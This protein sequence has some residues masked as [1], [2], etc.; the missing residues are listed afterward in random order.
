MSINFNNFNGFKVEDLRKYNPLYYYKAFKEEDIEDLDELIKFCQG[1]IIK[2]QS[3]GDSFETRKSMEESDV[4]IRAKDGTL[5]NNYSIFDIDTVIRNYKDANR[6]YGKLKEKYNIDPYLS[7]KTEDFRIIKCLNNNLDKKK[8][9]MFLDS[10]N[11]SVDYFLKVTHTKAFNN[12]VYYREMYYMYLINATIHRYINKTMY[13]YFDVDKYSKK[14]LKNA[15][16]SNGL[17]YFDSFPLEYQRRTYKR[18]NDLIR[19][20]GTNDIFPII[21]DIFSLEAIDINKYFLAKEENDL[22]FYKTEISKLFNQFEDPSYEYEEIVNKDPYWRN[23]KEEV[24]NKKFNLLQ[25]KYISTDAIIDIISN[26]KGLSYL[27]SIINLMKEDK[28]I[29][30]DDSFSLMNSRISKSRIDVFDAIITLNT[31]LINYIKWNDRIKNNKNM[32]IYGYNFESNIKPIVDD[33]RS[34][35][36][37]RQFDKSDYTVYAKMLNY[38]NIKKFK[39]RNTL[40]YQDVINEYESS[41]LAKR[42]FKFISEILTGVNGSTQLEYYIENDLIIDGMRYLWT[43]VTKKERKFSF[44][45]ISYY[46]HFMDVYTKFINVMIRDGRINEN[47]VYSIMIEDE[48]IQKELDKFVYNMNMKVLNDKYKEYMDNK[49][50]DNINSLVSTIR[51][52][53]EVSIKNNKYDYTKQI[54][55][56]PS[57]NSYISDILTYEDLNEDYINVSEIMSMYKHNEDFRKQLEDLIINSK[58]PHLTKKFTKLYEQ[59]FITKSSNDIFNGYS[60]YSDYLMSKNPDLYYYTIVESNIYDEDVF[61]REGIFRERIFELVASIDNHLNLKEQL[62]TNSNFS[63]VVNFIIDYVKVLV[64]LFKS[65]TTDMIYTGMLFK[66]DNEFENKINLLD[67]TDVKYSGTT[68]RVDKVNILDNRNI[69]DKI[70]NNENIKVTDSLFINS[71]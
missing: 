39:N 40:D 11:E 67:E 18:L 32:D 12:Q 6:Y 10:Y 2:D 70:N 38:L 52:S 30:E 22:K 69:T 41:D 5:D 48:E 61:D 35:I 57:L 50:P 24:L 1:L 63:S 16:I 7:R 4:Y 27:Y 59:L 21:E 15:F 20:K 43:Q 47:D 49:T 29:I 68:E 31:L 13:N 19:N 51:K 9:R 3:L 64:L 26:S 33:I 55:R 28:N 62:F 37:S 60:T 45:N 71:Y 65:Y 23:T 36:Y 17:D 8:E 44:K 66:L 56:Y 46:T 54:K 58:D 25:T 34:Y 42:Q 14:D 53:I